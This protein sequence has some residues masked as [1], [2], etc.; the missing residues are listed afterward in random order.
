MRAHLVGCH[1]VGLPATAHLVPDA[2]S[3]LTRVYLAAPEGSALV[4]ASLHHLLAEPPDYK[5]PLDWIPH[6]DS[7]QP[8]L[9][10]SLGQLV[11]ES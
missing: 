9:P 3:M 8:F 1:A 6:K 2:C 5:R 7:M 11:D 4:R 10:L